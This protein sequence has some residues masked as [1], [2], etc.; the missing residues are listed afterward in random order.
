MQTFRDRLQ[1]YSLGTPPGQVAPSY[2]GFIRRIESI[3]AVEP[4][5]RIGVRL[6]EEG[7]NSPDEFAAGRSLVI[8]LELWDVGRRELRTRKLEQIAHYV[9]AR[10][11]EVLDRYIGPSITMLRARMASDI[12]QALLAVEDIA[13]VDL[14][15]EPDVA[16]GEA[17]ELTIADLPQLDDMAGEPLSSPPDAGSIG[18]TP[19]CARRSC[20]IV[21]EGSFTPGPKASTI[22]KA[23]H[24][25]QTSVPITVRFS[26]LAG[27]P[28]I[29]DNREL[30]SPRGLAIK[31]R[32]P[33]G[34][35]T[36][37]VA[38]RSTDPRHR[39]PTISA[40]C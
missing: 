22:S 21:L 23:S 16:T 5:D 32:L 36:V 33:H 7:F 40:T 15:P 27:I 11:G 24:L 38:T 18:D 3:G 29:P 17:L 14:P 6:R 19:W 26:N 1:A 39:R 13:A 2:S 10:G 34:A 30:A 28:D 12:I 25:Q 20:R 37:I 9:D 35:D 8:D 31:F 4:R